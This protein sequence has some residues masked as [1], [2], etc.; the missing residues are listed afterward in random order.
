MPLIQKNQK[1]RFLCIDV[2]LLLVHMKKKELLLLEMAFQIV[3]PPNENG[4]ELFIYT[5]FFTHLLLQI[6]SQTHLDIHGVFAGSLYFSE[7]TGGNHQQ[8]TTYKGPVGPI[9]SAPPVSW[10]FRHQVSKEP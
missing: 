10:I 4:A 7:L 2:P 3:S 1:Q 5:T 8:L 6:V 9:I